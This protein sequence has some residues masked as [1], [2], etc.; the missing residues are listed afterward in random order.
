MITQN[1]V[2]ANE[3]NLPFVDNLLFFFC[4]F[5]INRIGKLYREFR[6]FGVF[7]MQLS[8]TQVIIRNVRTNKN[9]LHRSHL[10]NKAPITLLIRLWR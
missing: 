4:F 7:S 6:Q 5:F 8:L 1:G 2:A 3:Q 9:L 10:T